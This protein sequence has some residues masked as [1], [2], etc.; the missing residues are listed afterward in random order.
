MR[1]KG[2]NR[3]VAC[4]AIAAGRAAHAIDAADVLIIKTVNLIKK[5][6]LL[7]KEHGVGKGED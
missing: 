1:F 2:G 4:T 6:E 7:R 5:K 3:Y